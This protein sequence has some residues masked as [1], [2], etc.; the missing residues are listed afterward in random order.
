MWI[1]LMLVGLL[2]VGGYAEEWYLQVC[3]KDD[4]PYALCKGVKL[5]SGL[6]LVDGEIRVLPTTN[7]TW[8]IQTDYLVVSSSDAKAGVVE[9]PAGFAGKEVLGVNWG[10]FVLTK[11]A[12]GALVN[13]PLCWSEGV[14]PSGG[15]GLNF[16]LR[17]D[18][19]EKDSWAVTVMFAGVERRE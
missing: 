17:A 12:P 3:K 8:V 15:R 2:S 4:S 7:G 11:V 13:C 10:L 18:S 5:G 1:A 16:S 14:T 9:V 6:E 19:P